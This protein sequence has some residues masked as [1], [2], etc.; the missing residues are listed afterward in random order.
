MTI[1]PTRARGLLDASTGDLA[2]V[3]QQRI[4]LVRRG[5]VPVDVTPGFDW[6]CVAVGGGA[7]AVA[8]ADAVTWTGPDGF[9]QHMTAPGS[10]AS[11]L[12][13]AGRT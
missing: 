6:T 8:G 1:T 12:A 11:R 13:V 5:A 9:T 2:V 7:V 10:G 4:T 3:T